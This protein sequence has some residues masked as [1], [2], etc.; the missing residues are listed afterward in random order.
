MISSCQV[1]ISVAARPRGRPVQRKILV[2]KSLTIPPESEAL[3]QFVCFNLLDDR[4][5]LFKPTPHSYLTL[6]SH[7]LN[8]STHRVL[9]R[10]ASHR[11]I[12]L[13]RR[14]RLGTLTEIPYGNCFQVAL[15]LELAKHPPITPNHQAGIRVP[16]LEPDLETRLANEI[17]VYRELLAVQQISDLVDEFS[18]IWKPSGFV[19]IPSERWMTVPLRADWQSHLHTIKPRVYPLGNNARALVNETF[20]KLQRQGRLVYTQTHTLFS[21]P[22]FVVWKPGPNGKKG[23]AVVDIKRLNDLVVPDTYPLPLQSNIT[24]TV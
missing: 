7:I 20:D 4:D 9:V 24:A 14:Q 19:Q 2:D 1:T 23:R 17:R 11:P 3:V 22:V 18:S 15:D 5:F 13:S 6:F 16:T 21:F 10:N 12:L 8:N